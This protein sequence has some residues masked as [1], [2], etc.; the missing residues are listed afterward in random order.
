MKTSLLSVSAGICAYNEEK[1]VGRL[2]EA[3]QAQELSQAAIREMFVVSSG[4]TD[5]TDTIVLA[6]SEKDSRVRLVRQP[7]R[8]GKASAI[9][10]FLKLASGDLC[11]LISADVLPE[12]DAVERMCLAFRDEKVGMVGGRVVPLNRT[13][14]FTG[15]AGH[16]LWGMHNQIALKDP[17]LGEMAMFRNVVKSIPE[18]T[19]TDEA[20]VE[21]AITQNGFALRYVPEAIVYNRAPET[22]SDFLRQRRRIYAGH[23]DLKRRFHY[24]TSTMSV[25]VLL[26]IAISYFGWSPRRNLWALDTI[27]LEAYARFLGW[28]D[29][30]VK[31]KSHAVWEMVPTTKTVAGRTG[32]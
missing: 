28:Y 21:A 8:R 9:N 6:C 5:N 26:P 20:Y 11:L 7:T 4:S 16:M 1:N 13:D 15:F 23:L 29:F 10:E 3:L 17:K 18:D 22:V 12:K 24:Q 2:I 19:A 14:C 27:L 25:K 30:R 31:K 32:R